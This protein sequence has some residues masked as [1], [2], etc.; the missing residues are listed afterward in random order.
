MCGLGTMNNQLEACNIT[1]VDQF[2]RLPIDFNNFKKKFPSKSLKVDDY[3]KLFVSLLLLS[4]TPEPDIFTTLTV[5]A[6]KNELVN[7]K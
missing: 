1:T 3:D 7:F 5:S 4:R 2:R 6:I